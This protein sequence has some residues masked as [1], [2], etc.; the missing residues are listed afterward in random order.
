MTLN[1]KYLRERELVKG[2]KVNL[3][4]KCEVTVSLGVLFTRLYGYGCLSLGEMPQKEYLGL[5]VD[6]RFAWW[7]EN[8]NDEE[9][10]G[11]SGT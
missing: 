9:A 5:G 1:I 7:Y 4:R 6:D 2:L 8:V 3:N 11:V 10:D